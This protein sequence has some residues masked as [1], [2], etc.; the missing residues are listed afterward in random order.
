MNALRIVLTPRRASLTA[1]TLL[2]AMLSGCSDESES[3]RDVASRADA[4]G[5]RSPDAAAE[6]HNPD[7]MEA[8]NGNFFLADPTEIVA[9]EETILRWSVPD[10]AYCEITPDIGHISYEGQQP[11]QPR[12][13]TMFTLTCPGGLG[14]AILH[15]TVS[16]V[17]SS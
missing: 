8:E 11:T 14:P 2:L 3:Q 15:T 7:A 5:Q 16:V 9:G 17:P 6:G 4:A 1:A 10:G 12:T 13:T